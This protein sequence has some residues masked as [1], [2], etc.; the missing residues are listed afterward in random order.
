MLLRWLPKADALTGTNG[1][2]PSSS[3][4]HKEAQGLLAHTRQ[5]VPKR[6]S[7]KKVTTITAQLTTDNSTLRRLRSTRVIRAPKPSRQCFCKHAG[8]KF[9]AV[10]SA[11]ALPVCFYRT[12]RQAMHCLW[13]G[14]EQ[15]VW[16]MWRRHSGRACA[17]CQKTR[18]TNC[19]RCF[20][21]DKA[22]Q[23]RPM[24]E[25]QAHQLRTLLFR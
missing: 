24:S 5:D 2:L 12:G 22:H 13:A 21:E 14:F 18:R 10:L 3:Q 4:P 20:S 11:R 25:N 7:Q 8:S 23:L 17:R 6:L 16:G 19:A 9:A 1:R 15:N